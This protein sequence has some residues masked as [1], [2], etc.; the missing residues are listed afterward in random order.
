MTDDRKRSDKPFRAVAWLNHKTFFQWTFRYYK[1]MYKWI[2]HPFLL[3]L[4]SI[5]DVD[6]M[7]DSVTKLRIN[8]RKNWSFGIAVF[9]K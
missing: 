3:I 9:L 4:D 2:L 7:K 5:K 8:R 6:F 1:G